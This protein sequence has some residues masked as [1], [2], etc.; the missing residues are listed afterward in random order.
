MG[1]YVKSGQKIILW[2]GEVLFTQRYLDA[3][4]NHFSL[5]SFPDLL[6]SNFL[7]RKY[8][9]RELVLICVL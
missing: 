8:L 7:N 5:I 2:L 4:V 9:L 3:A 1:L 6:C